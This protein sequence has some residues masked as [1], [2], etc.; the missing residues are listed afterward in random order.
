MSDESQRSLARNEVLFRDT[1]E[2]IERGQWPGDR[3]KRVR[4]RCE[5]SH[6]DCGEAV[7]ITLGEYEQLRSEPR[8]F[9]VSPG[10]ET[11]EIETV[12]SRAPG[13]V[14]VEKQDGAGEAAQALD[15]RS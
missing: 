5:C 3:D 2:A 13:H 8:R 4:F 14:I 7:E 6:M 11:P 10:H 12:I 15:P 9:L 1:N